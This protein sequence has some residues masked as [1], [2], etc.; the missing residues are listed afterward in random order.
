MSGEERCNVAQNVVH[1]DLP[2]KVAVAG[3]IEEI[4]L[5]NLA[6]VGFAALL[7][8]ARFRQSGQPNSA[9]QRRPKPCLKEQLLP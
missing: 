5:R 9:L 1:K 8:F 7:V 4:M 6:F 2:R 3:S